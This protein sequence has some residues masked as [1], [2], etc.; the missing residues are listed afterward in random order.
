MLLW[1]VAAEAVMGNLKLFRAIT[2]AH[3]AEDPEQNAN[4]LSG[5]RLDRADL[6]R[7]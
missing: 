2:K 7:H 3:E 4:S 5:D 1:T 6:D